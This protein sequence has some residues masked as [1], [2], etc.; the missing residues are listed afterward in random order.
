MTRLYRS[1]FFLLGLV[2]VSMLVIAG[3][4]L[5]L[6]P[7]TSRA[8]PSTTFTVNST[9]D[10]GDAAPGNGTCA[11]SGGQCTLRAAIEEANALANN[12]TIEF[13]LS[14]G[15]VIT[16]Y[17]NA[18]R[19]TDQAG[20][21]ID[22]DINDDGK[23]DI[24]LRFG[25]G[26]TWS[27]IGVRSSYNRIEGL[28]IGGFPVHGIYIEGT[29]YTATNNTILNNYIG[30][31]LAG[32]QA[33]SNTYYGIYVESGA[34]GA[35][36]NTIQGNLVSGNGQWGIYIENAPNTVVISNQIGTNVAGTAALPNLSS[37]LAISGALTT[38]VQANLI[39]GNAGN[40]IYIQ[41]STNTLILSNTV[42]LD[43]TGNTLLE[44]QGTAGIY[45][46]RDGVATT[47]RGN[48][49]SGNRSNGIY[50]GAGTHG[51]L[52]AGN[53][54]GTNADGT[55][56]RGNGIDTNRDGI[57]IKDAF[58]NT[59]GGP[60]PADRNLISHNKRAGVFI[61]GSAAQNNVV[62]GNYIGTDVTGSAD[63]GNG[64][65]IGTDTGHGGVYIQ[66]GASNNRVE[67]NL[68]R[69]N[70][71]GVRLLGSG[72]GYTPPQANQ[73][74][75]NTVTSNDAY[76]I[77][78]QVTH[79]NTTH[80]TPADGDNLIAYNTITGTG[81]PAHTG[82]GIFNYG[83]SPRILTNTVS[84]NRTF[85]I[86]NRVWFGTDGPA[87]AADDILSVPLI[88]GNTIDGNGN[89]GI[90]SRDTAPLNRYTLGADNTIGNNSGE[91]DVSQRWFGV[92][93]V[94]TGTQPITV[95]LTVTV[96]R[97][98]GVGQACPAGACVG[99]VY[100]GGAWGPAGFV[101]T[102]VE[103]ADGTSTWFEIIEYEITWNNQWVTYTPH[104]ARVGGA[105]LGSR[106]FAFDGVTTTAEISGDVGLPTC[107]P[108]GITS[109]PQHSFCRYQIAQVTVFRPG[110]DSDDDTIPDDVEG[111][112]DTDGDGTPDYLDTDSD[113]D[114]IPDETEGTGDT[115][116]DG[117]P[118][119]QDTDSDDDG[120]PDA[121]EGT[122]DSDGD[123]TP[124]YQDTDSDDDGIPD[125]TEGGVN[126]TDGDGTPDYLDPDS[127]GDGVRDGAEGTGD[128][129]GDGTPNYRDTDSDDDGT[130]DGDDMD[131]DGDGIS[132]VDEGLVD[133][134]GTEDD[135]SIDTDG[136]GS[137]DYLDTDS[138]NDGIP[139][140]TEGTQDSDGDST[141]DF[142]DTDSDGDGIPDAAE[143]DTDQK[144][145]TTDDLCTNYAVDSD[146]D[147]ILNCQD[148]DVDGDGIP[149]YL[150]PDSDGDGTPDSQESRTDPEP[151]PFGDPNLPAWLDPVYRIRLPIVL[152]NF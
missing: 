53:K 10:T 57:Q 131:D 66:D 54:I 79:N 7:T 70:Y 9:A 129:D 33:V 124:N 45:I 44:N 116:G 34:Y 27:G 95:G 83:A 123:G 101:Y 113:N 69:Y 149:N 103:K 139:D 59:I 92:V 93:E 38:T 50:L 145:S 140:A 62:Q 56:G 1:P 147:G 43:I 152:R 48:V 151:P 84:N 2:G 4:L 136:D 76:G 80:L 20:V 122:Q 13:G 138:D 91:P 119:F 71:I 118:D 42:G 61:S 130:P 73:I 135:T 67:G 104:L 15:S 58:D 86:V 127:D 28:A 106:S 21:W 105:A 78:N 26:G 98:G 11:D 68:I 144:G 89:D 31:D 46:S 125:E 75:S 41:A 115:D 112:G 39:S 133:Q 107:I 23:P 6:H 148:N 126:D 47:M 40:G 30:T 51:T 121:T 63:L 17:T 143:W 132:D 99:N 8:A 109:D 36:N 88:A 25:G 35:G 24:V 81:Y 32:T 100:N 102:D 90:Q 134:E 52:I 18:L 142:R 64:W 97:V 96:T 108:T 22:G 128:V 37:G 29:A 74:L 12:D 94:L 19:L 14:A 82:I 3:M 110:A 85:G 16:V 87:N 5:I 120:I 141:P 137:P 60:N 117:T 72:T 65:N 49:V 146:G 111:T 114:G 77:V 55:E 150:D